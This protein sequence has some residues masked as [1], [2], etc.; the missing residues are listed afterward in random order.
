MNKKTNKTKRPY[1][2]PIPS[3]NELIN[4][5]G[6]K[7]H[8]ISLKALLIHFDIQDV[9]QK[10][11]LQKLIFR[12]NKDKLIRKNKKGGLY[13][14]NSKR[15]VS[16]VVIE[17]QEGYG[18]LSVEGREKDIF[19]P[20]DQMR[21]L[22]DGDEISVKVFSSDKNRESGRLIKIL[23]RGQKKVQGRL[24]FSR[25]YYYVDIYKKNLNKKLFIN[26]SNLGEAE[27]G[28]YV[29]AD[30]IKYP[31]SKRDSMYGRI[32]SI[33][34]DDKKEG[35]F[36]DIAIR[37]FDLPDIWPDQVRSQAN[38]FRSHKSISKAE[39]ARRT[40][41]REKFFITIDGSHAKDFDDAVYCESFKSGWKLFIAIADVDHYVKTDSPIDREAR[42]RGTSVYFPDRVIPMLPEILSNELC[43]IKPNEERLTLVCEVQIASSGETIKSEFYEA[44][45]ESKA[46]LTY[47]QVN[48]LFISNN[49]GSFSGRV[50][51]NI[52]KSF[53]LYKSLSKKR[54]SR[55]AINLEIPQSTITFNQDGS[56]NGIDS[57]ERNNAHRLIEEF[58]ITA[59]VEAAKFINKNKIPSLYR[60]H[61]KPN[62]DDYNNLRSY[63][64]SQKI[65]APDPKNLKPNDFNMILNQLKSESG[66]YPLS[67]MML[68]SFS[69][70]VYHSK[71]IG[72]FGLALDSYAH[73]TSPI[74]RYPDLLVHRAI[75]HL[76]QSKK[77]GKF[78]YSIAAMEALGQICSSHERRAEKATRDVELMLKC[79]YMEDKIGSKYKG[80]VIG[81]TGFGLFVQLK[82]IFVE[83][84]V[85]IST[86]RDDY[87]FFDEANICLIG[88]KNKQI[89]S[90]GDRVEVKVDEVDINMRKINL[91][92]IKR[93]SG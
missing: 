25:G 67:M 16:G 8:P 49:S 26:K 21:S 80:E 38:E 72:H 42:H 90:I 50:V 4:F 83:G 56:I 48:N 34:G 59:N 77:V 5:L 69:Q 30:I 39:I 57:I 33:I 88:E 23:N 9:N 14:P 36:T 13:L 51:E 85:H 61:E 64:L 76:I 82:N 55:G 28:Q 86:L 70:A 93:I 20:I 74:R 27:V 37:A 10:Q 15:T 62:S 22:M 46:R 52:L 19:L 91:S 32:L 60:N 41:L 31:S 73:F 44:V 84:L 63:L 35:I 1:Q 3:P 24:M 79:R 29:E 43:S 65:K 78:H 75:R 66:R 11:V 92:L 45:I 89:Y 12:M 6:K 54:R 18:F 87:Y 71:K 47:S 81:V 17:N 40:D 58:M 53:S 68:R 7:N 2:H